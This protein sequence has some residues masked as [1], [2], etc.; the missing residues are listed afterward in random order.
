M[1]DAE[2]KNRRAFALLAAAV[3]SLAAFSPT[4]E[5]G[6][7][8]DDGHSIEDNPS[9]RSFS[10]LPRWLTDIKAFSPLASN[11]SYRPALLITL[12]A[13]YAWGNGQPW[14]FHFISIFLHIL[15]AWWVA[16]LLGRILNTTR[17]AGRFRVSMNWWVIGGA[18]VFAAHPLLTEAVAY[19]SARS[20]L[21]AAVFMFGSVLSYIIAREERRRGYLVWSFVLL[22]LALT[23][24]LIAVTGVAMMIL[25][26]LLLSPRPRQ[27]GFRDHVARLWPFVLFTVGFS[28]FHEWLAGV[29]THRSPVGSY[30]FFLTESQVWIRFIR[31]FFWPSDLCADLTMP[32]AQSPL[33]PRV[34]ISLAIAVALGIAAWWFKDRLPAFSFGILWYFVALGPTHTIMPL[35]EPAS[36]HRVYIALPGLLFAVVSLLRYFLDQRERVRPAFA[37]LLAVVVAA[38]IWASRE[39]STVWQTERTL[40]GSVIECAPDN[41]RAFLNYGRGLWQEGDMRGAREA[42]ERCAALWP[43]YAFCY[44]NLSALELLEENYEQ[45][46]L[47]ARAAAKIDQ[48]GIYTHLA[49]GD[50]ALAEKRHLEAKYHF[51]RGAIVAPGQSKA[52]EGGAVARFELGELDEA[53]RRLE[54]LAAIGA[55]GAEGWF[56]WGFLLERDQKHDAALAAYAQSLAHRARH[57][58]ARFNRGRLRLL[59]EDYEGAKQDFMELLALK[60]APPGTEQNLAVARRALGEIP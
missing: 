8:F 15:G 46:T 30:S 23:T 38:Q 39:R 54:P 47:Q 31:Q 52:V 4:M 22:V 37:G 9:L 42:F 7:H 20:S 33:E 2:H 3:V 16:L 59:R 28:I 12:G 10:E 14:A 6:F 51:D 60:D 13:S 41:G 45:A 24:K 43:G 57:R 21:Q 40:W 11:R 50:A 53:K 49:L 18:A 25:W 5:G 27:L 29:A 34:A 19:I 44:Y 36:E 17:R 35:A 1:S 56:V 32:W 26:E 55:L 48:D 58:R